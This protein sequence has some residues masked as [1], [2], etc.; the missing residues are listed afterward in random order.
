MTDMTFES[1]YMPLELVLNIITQSVPTQEGIL[2]PSHP[3][4]KALLTWS[5]VSHETRK[6][7]QRLL[8][9]NCIYLDSQHRM[10]IFVNRLSED[11]DIRKHI[12]SM[13]LAP[14]QPR[15]K[16]TG[17]EALHLLELL[18]SLFEYTG[19]TLRR[20]TLDRS[21]LNIC[22]R[23]EIYYSFLALR[24]LE[25]V[26][27]LRWSWD[28]NL[29][30]WSYSDEEQ[31]LDVKPLHGPVWSHWPKLKRLALFNP[32]PTNSFND[33]LDRLPALETLVMTRM[34]PVFLDNLSKSLR[35]RKAKRPLKIVLVDAEQEEVTPEN[36]RGQGT[37]DVVDPQRLR[38]VYIHKVP[39]Y[40]YPE[41]E[42]CNEAHLTALQV[43]QRESYY[44]RTE[45]CQ[46]Y[47]ERA[48]R[49]GTLWDWEGEEVLPL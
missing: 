42:L 18:R 36:L 45:I 4:T 6:H 34:N 48:A 31:Y 22:Y 28:H 43:G 2:P 24:N 27:H 11:A 39:S 3:S 44:W 9:Q 1:T 47:I 7:A 49:S 30:D 5:L 15:E 35:S 8:A 17:A 16:G 25:E 32:C 37:W 26:V 46:A 12:S 13:F 29:E 38:R 23:K 33:G 10:R 20:L 40:L 14:A 19:P 41:L 21:S